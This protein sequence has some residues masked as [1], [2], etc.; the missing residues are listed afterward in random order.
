MSTTFEVR[1]GKSGSNV[2]I[3]CE[4]AES[5][6]YLA[7]PSS[8]SV[9]SNGPKMQNIVQM[10][11]LELEYLR[12]A[13]TVQEN[14]VLDAWFQMVLAEMRDK[15]FVESFII[16]RKSTKP[17]QNNPL[18]DGA[19]IA[20]RIKDT[21]GYLRQYP[22]TSELLA[23][24]RYWF[25]E[26]LEEK[27]R[28]VS[29]ISRH[30]QDVYTAYRHS[31]QVLQAE[32]LESIRK[33][34]LKFQ[35]SNNMVENHPTPP[36]TSS[37]QKLRL[38]IDNW[39]KTSLGNT[40]LDVRS[41]FE[42]AQQPKSLLSFLLLLRENIKSCA[43]PA[44]LQNPRVPQPPQ[45]TAPLPVASR[46]RTPAEYQDLLQLRE[47]KV[48]QATY[49]YRQQVNAL[50]DKKRREQEAKRAQCREWTSQ[51]DKWIQQTRVLEEKDVVS[52]ISEWQNTI[53][54]QRNLS[55][56][57]RRLM[58]DADSKLRNISVQAVN[59]LEGTVQNIKA[60]YASSEAQR[61]KQIEAVLRKAH[62][63][64]EGEIIALR[65][66]MRLRETLW[67]DRQCIRVMNLWATLSHASAPVRQ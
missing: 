38:D 27:S 21:E 10:D 45:P 63:L 58:Q 16:P 44:A 49:E 43:E 29:A 25:E 22:P 41:A 9:V 19:L 53:L 18:P 15:E 23:Q 66:W 11:S 37:F 64:S 57:L 24:V 33:L 28:A 40:L 65:A 47:Q 2:D 51:L 20:A 1:I 32:V 39:L 31:M 61:S 5:P 3:E 35:V 60:Q 67:N 12:K 56:E 55:Q 30:R 13:F 7:E 8:S 34:F 36:N 48:Q 62:N 6:I 4:E 14:N 26:Q 59:K 17:P 46:T 52:G 50:K 54:R 42:M